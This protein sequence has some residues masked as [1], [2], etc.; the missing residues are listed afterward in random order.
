MSGR[1]RVVAPELR[2]STATSSKNWGSDWEN[3]SK[4]NCT[5]SVNCFRACDVTLHDSLNN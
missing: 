3:I 2:A 4:L 1:L 5:S